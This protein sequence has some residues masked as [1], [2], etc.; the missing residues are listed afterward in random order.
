[1]QPRPQ[2]PSAERTSTSTAYDALAR[3]GL[4][5][6]RLAL[7]SADCAAL[8]ALAGDWLARGV[9]VD[10][11]V[12]TLAAGLPEQV[13]SPGAFVRRRLID[14]LPPERPAPAT[15]AQPPRPAP[16]TL[17]ECTDCGVPGRPEALP[18]GLCRACRPGTAG[19]P[20]TPYRPETGTHPTAPPPTPLTPADV[21]RNAT[22]LRRTL[23][24]RHD[25]PQA[26]A[27]APSRLA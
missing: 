2:Q 24:A 18:G 10:Y 19:G 20:E 26:P 4:H 14:K 3:L 21:Q 11:L 22:H 8:A 25:P 23:A 17:M 6:P 27:P 5:D 9:T 12:R 13:H 7:S 1:M 15:D 16:R